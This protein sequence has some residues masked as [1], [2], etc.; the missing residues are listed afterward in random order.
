VISPLPQQMSPAIEKSHECLSPMRALVVDDSP[1]FLEVACA[2]LQLQGWVEVVG[3]AGDG[4]EAVAAVAELAPDLVLM[5]VQMPRMSGTTAATLIA[6]SFPETAVLLMS[7]ENSAELR[8]RCLEA[9]AEAF[10][11]KTTFLSDMAAAL[12]RHAAT[13]ANA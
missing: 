1:D 8:A 9:G 7:A 11:Y 10:I 4:V 13:S 5:D 3:T 6:A 12:H 2:N